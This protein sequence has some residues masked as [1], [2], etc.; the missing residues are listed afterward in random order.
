MYIN[1]TYFKSV[2]IV[3]LIMSLNSCSKDEKKDTEQVTNQFNTYN[4]TKNSILIEFYS[5][6]SFNRLIIEDYNEYPLY[7]KSKRKGQLYSV[8]YEG[9]DSYKL[10]LY[11][12]QEYKIQPLERKNSNIQLQCCQQNMDK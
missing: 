11:F 2:L 7:I 9:D 5:A 10:F 1:Q 4:I 6:K 3:A 12:Y 8:I